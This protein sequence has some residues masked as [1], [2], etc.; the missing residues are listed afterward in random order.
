[1]SVWYD[2]KRGGWVAKY[3]AGGRQYWVKGSP[4]ATREIAEERER[5]HREYRRAARLE[6]L[7]REREGRSHTVYLLY[8]DDELL[9]V[10]V[11]STGHRRLDQHRRIRPWWTTVTRAEF[12]HYSDQEAALAREQQLIRDLLPPHN[13][14]FASTGGSCAT[15]AAA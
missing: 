14:N 1:M 9:Y 12:E 5:K 4:F 10:G 11:T 6:V 2:R 13:S 3:C 7:R 15:G 8:A